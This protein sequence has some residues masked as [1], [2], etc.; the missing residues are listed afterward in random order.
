MH[1]AKGLEAP[2]IFL[3]DT[4]Q[5]P[6]PPETLLWTEREALPLWRPRAEFTV[7]VYTVEREAVRR[8][9]LQEYR[10]LLY[11][12]L[13]RAQDRL[14]VCGWQT[15]IRRRRCAGTRSAAPGSPR[16]PPFE[17]DATALIGRDGWSGEGFRL[18]GAQTASPIL[19]SPAEIARLG[20]SL[21]SWVRKPPRPSPTRRSRCFRHGRARSSR[22]SSRR[23]G[24]AGTTVSSAGFSCTGY[25]RACPSC[26]PRSTRRRPAGFSRYRCTDS[27]ARSRTSSAARRSRCFATRISPRF[28]AR[29]RK[30]KCRLSGWSRPVLSGQIDRLVVEETACWSSITR[31]CARRPRPSGGLTSLSVSSPS[32]GRLARIY[33]GH[34]IR[35]ALLWTEGRG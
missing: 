5:L 9:E 12:G 13:S 32:T 28:S 14:Y 4:M 22:P 1:G 10:R 3:P 25:C 11:V 6:K 34:E 20:R 31:R 27:V 23:S 17:F 26:R 24:W 15:R 18:A 8:R 7:P 30:L 35:C 2:I 19:E 33:P 16:S 21:P 29:A